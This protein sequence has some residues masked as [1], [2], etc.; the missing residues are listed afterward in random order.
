MGPPAMAVLVKAMRAMLNRGMRIKLALKDI[1]FI[2][3][4]TFI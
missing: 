3:N 4:A 1:R 2:L